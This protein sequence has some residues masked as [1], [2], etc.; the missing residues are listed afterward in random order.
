MADTTFDAIEQRI[1]ELVGVIHRLKQEKEAMAGQLEKK[2]LEIRDMGQKMEGL[3][4]E[5]NEI[6][7]R[8]DSILSRLESVEL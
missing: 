5:R 2:D 8:V 3:M 6:R 1:T 4:R 7:E